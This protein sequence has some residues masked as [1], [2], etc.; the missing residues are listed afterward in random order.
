MVKKGQGSYSLNILILTPSS[1]LYGFRRLYTASI[2]L[3]LQEGEDTQ[4]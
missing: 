4:K 3:R 2:T 1:S